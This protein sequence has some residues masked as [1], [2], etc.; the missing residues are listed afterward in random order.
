MKLKLFISLLFLGILF[1]CTKEEIPADPMKDFYLLET[2]NLD[3]Y[4][5]E[6]YATNHQWT[7]GYNQVYFRIKDAE[8][9]TINNPDISWTPVMHMVSKTHSC[10]VSSVSS[11][12]FEGIGSGF[13]I[14]QMPS[15]DSEYWDISFNITINGS[16][17][18]V[19]KEVEVNLP[20][21]NRKRVSVFMDANEQ[22]YVLALVEP[23]EPKI[24]V[25]D[26]RMKLFKMETMM[27]FSVVPYG[28]ILLD[29]RMPSMDN[30][31]SPN[32]VDLSYNP[33]TNSYEG[34]LSLTM[35]GYWKL[36]L[37]YL[38]SNGQLVKGNEVTDTTPSSNLYLE[39][40][41]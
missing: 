23:S 30:H 20:L 21:D 11:S 29:P 4:R 32:N 15:N 31:S 26:I 27:S 24:A 8:G 36:N 22:K 40:E 25:N 10:P 1:S 16:S 5:M 35:S 28:T 41:F 37:Q 7:L 13:V 17:M 38:D 9:K 14:F 39:L 6:L 18:S 3:S 12:E 19:T 2:I 34:K 33:G